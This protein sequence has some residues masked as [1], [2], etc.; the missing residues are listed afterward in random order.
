MKEQLKDLKL[1]FDTLNILTNL[2]SDNLA[3]LKVKC[4]G[5]INIV[6]Q[7]PQESV[8]KKVPDSVQK[9]NVNFGKADKTNNDASSEAIKKWVIE[10]I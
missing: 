5:D 10:Q 6:N 2:V 8:F 4:E 7:I 9:Q 1:K 3:A